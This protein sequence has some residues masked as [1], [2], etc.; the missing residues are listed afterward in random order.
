VNASRI[1][2]DA[3]VAVKWFTDEV[4]AEEAASVLTS[5]VDLL[6]P[7]LIITEVSNA[8]LKKLKLGDMR[9]DH[10]V[11]AID[12]LGQELTFVTLGDYPVVAFEIAVT[13]QRSVYDSLYVGLALQE[14]CQFVTADEKLYN[15]LRGV[16]PEA[17]L[18]LGDVTAETI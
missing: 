8:L 1:V 3:S 16:Y 5:Y 10:A 15:S 11:A 18:W 17:L 13:H 12:R 2:V 14:G 7:P 9:R 6:A 4:L